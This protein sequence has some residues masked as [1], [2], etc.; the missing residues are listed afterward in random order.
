MA[1][2]FFSSPAMEKKKKKVQT[3]PQYRSHGLRIAE[4]DHQRSVDNEPLKAFYQP[5]TMI[6]AQ[7]HL[8]YF[9]M[10]EKCSSSILFK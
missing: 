4:Q 9:C 3:G 5:S 2:P 6:P 7:N 8:P 10:K 1:F